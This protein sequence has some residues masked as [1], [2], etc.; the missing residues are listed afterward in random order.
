MLVIIYI[1]L[2]LAIF[3]F[4]D[5]PSSLL[6]NTTAVVHTFITSHLNESCLSSNLFH[7]SASDINHAKAQYLLCHSLSQKPSNYL[8]WHIILFSTP[9]FGKP[10]H[11]RYILTLY[12]LKHPCKYEIKKTTG[13]S[14]DIYSFIFVLFLS[15]CFPPCNFSSFLPLSYT[16]C[17]FHILYANVTS[18]NL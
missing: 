11:F 9:G 16:H 7:P 15:T 3:A 10:F 18:K 8:V 12:R 17:L 14:K 4:T 1:Q 2:S 13:R 6:T 5:I